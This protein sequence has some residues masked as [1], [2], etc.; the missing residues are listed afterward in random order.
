MIFGTRVWLA[1]MSPMTGSFVLLEQCP[2]VYDVYTLNQLF[3]CVF[4][5]K[6]SREPFHEV[7]EGPDSCA[8]YLEERMLPALRV[9][10]PSL[11][12]IC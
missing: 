5:S 12:M 9:L 4:R 7:L 1:S 6:D 8:F 3:S 11:L 2:C 10:T